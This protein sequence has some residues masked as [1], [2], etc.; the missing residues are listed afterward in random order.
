MTFEKGCVR[1]QHHRNAARRGDPQFPGQVGVVTFQDLDQPAAQLGRSLPALVAQPEMAALGLRESCLGRKLARGDIEKAFYGGIGTQLQRAS[2][3]P[4]GLMAA[5]G[6][7]VDETERGGGVGGVGG[8]PGGALGRRHRLL[9]A[10]HLCQHGGIV[11]QDDRAIRS[12][13]QRAFE[14]ETCVLTVAVLHLLP[15]GDEETGGSQGRIAGALQ[16]SQGV[17]IHLAAAH[18]PGSKL[19]LALETLAL[20][21][22]RRRGGDRRAG[23]R[24][25]LD[26]FHQG[27]RNGVGVSSDFVLHPAAVHSNVAACEGATVL[28]AND[29]RPREGGKEQ[30]NRDDTKPHV[31]AF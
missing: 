14:V 4:H 30:Q 18:Q 21:V 22:R 12:E 26:P 11:G 6:A 28:Q 7:E 27:R 23:R 9:G 29:V 16:F 3:G 20:G 5:I 1:V 8:Q 15:S 24:I 13:H 31:G 17:G 10:P 25:G 19:R 2:P